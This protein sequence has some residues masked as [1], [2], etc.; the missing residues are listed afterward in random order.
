M[1][2]GYIK[3][4]RQILEWEWYSNLPARVLFIH[5]LLK[6]NWQDGEWQGVPYK[7]GEFI[8]SMRKLA[9]ET[10]LSVQQVRNTLT[11]LQKTHEITQ[12]STP[13]YTVISIVRYDDY[14]LDNTPTNKQTTHKPTTVKENKNIR[15]IS[16]YA[17][18]AQEA[19]ALRLEFGEKYDGLVQDVR[20]Y[21]EEHPE[22]RFGGWAKE[23]R[24]FAR[25]QSRWNKGGRS[26]KY[27]T[28]MDRALAAYD[29]EEDE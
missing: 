23:M 12:R 18:E 19:E 9:A 15:I 17:P 14:Q 25:N 29:E 11:N 5:C 28:P 21:F 16:L 3:L 7:R 27:S 2:K 20:D 1:T 13:N 24:K 8:T 4:H 26:R 10:G 22:K 6:A